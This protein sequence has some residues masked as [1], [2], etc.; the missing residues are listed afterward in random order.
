M[1]IEEIISQHRCKLDNDRTWRIT[2][3]RN[4]VLEDTLRAMKT[5]TDLD[6]NAKHIEVIFLGEPAIDEGG[7]KREF[8][9]LLM[10]SI[11]ASGILLDGAPGHRIPRRNV[12]AFKVC[13]MI[14]YVP[15]IYS[16]SLLYHNVYNHVKA[17]ADP[18]FFQRGSSYIIY[19]IYI[20][21]AIIHIIIL[22]NKVHVS[23]YCV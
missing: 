2:I 4:N 7:P 3:R 18:G 20:Y 11:D 5:S 10:Q 12:I 17:G 6:L 21:I 14:H 8:F 1:K 19:K 16:V 22:F 9:R 23:T 15:F 13:I